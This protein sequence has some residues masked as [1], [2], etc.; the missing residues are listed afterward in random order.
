MPIVYR[1]DFTRSFADF[2]REFVSGDV[3]PIAGRTLTCLNSS[4]SLVIPAANVLT[5]ASA[6]SLAVLDPLASAGLVLPRSETAPVP[7]PSTN[8]FTA[9]TADWLILLMQFPFQQQTTFRGE[10]GRWHRAA[11][12]GVLHRR[13]RFHVVELIM[14]QNWFLIASMAATL[15]IVWS[16][17]ATATVRGDDTPKLQSGAPQKL[18]GLIVGNDS[19]G[20]HAWPRDDAVDFGLTQLSKLVDYVFVAAIAMLGLV[21]KTLVFDRLNIKAGDTPQPLTGF[22]R[23]LSIG[24]IVSLSL[25]VVLG[26]LAYGTLPQM[27][28][29]QTFSLNDAIG[30]YVLGQYVASGLGTLLIGWFCICRIYFAS[31]TTSGADLAHP[32]RK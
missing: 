26:L 16:V 31:T 6:E 2:A 23:G 8:P 25:S 24:I 30:Y 10:A 28:T 4:G 14:N 29:A 15:A 3:G 11:R 9:A 18:E 17:H 22:E 7:K 1:L 19:I 32:R 5:A 12:R 20:R 13:S 27:I 21:V